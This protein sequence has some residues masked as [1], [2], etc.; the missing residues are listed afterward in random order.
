VVISLMI[1]LH[2]SAPFPR[3][4]RRCICTCAAALLSLLTVGS[5]QTAAA[6]EKKPAVE[7][8]N[9]AEAAKL[10]ADQKPVVLDLRTPAEFAAGHIAGAKNIDFRAPDFEQQIAQLD[11]STPYLLHCASG[12]RSSKALPLF[13][14]HGFRELH[15]LDGGFIA[16]EKAGL[17]VQK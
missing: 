2:N 10:I 4:L 1:T 8:V 17:P 5:W 15:H 14:K 16:W 3:Q 12:N 11:K 9:S 6:S 13:E 7:H